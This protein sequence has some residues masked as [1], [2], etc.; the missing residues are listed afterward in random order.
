M[1]AQTTRRIQ[2]PKNKQC[3]TLNFFPLTDMVP[4][5]LGPFLPFAALPVPLE[6]VPPVPVSV[7]DTTN[8]ST[9]SI[10]SAIA[11]PSPNAS[12]AQ[13]ASESPSSSP[14]LALSSTS[15]TQLFQP[16]I[17]T[18][19]GRSSLIFQQPS[20][21]L[22]KPSDAQK[23]SSKIQHDVN[24]ADQKIL[25]A[26]LTVLL[27]KHRLELMELADHH[28]KKI[29]YI[30]KLIGTSKHYKVQRAVNLENAKLHAKASEINAGQLLCLYIFALV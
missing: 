2:V 19:A 5:V 9:P 22:A 27:E 12:P 23:A 4:C 24:E 13:L 6:L 17:P 15:S 25:N 20:R 16:P 18:H 1:L 14:P 8:L 28:A 21:Q 10:P 11:S 7:P 29:S 3:V 26:E 30:D